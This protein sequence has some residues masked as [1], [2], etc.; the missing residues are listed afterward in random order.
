MRRETLL[1]LAP[2]GRRHPVVRLP[3]ANGGDP[4]TELPPLPGYFPVVRLRPGAIGLVEGTGSERPSLMVAGA[5]GQG[6]VI[7]ALSAAFWRLELLSSGVGGRPQTM[8]Q[9]WRNA[10]N[11]LAIKT[12]AGRVRA[13]T[14]R[15]V[16]RSGEPLIFVAQVFD[17]LL[18]PQEGAALQVALE[19]GELQFSLSDEGGG[20]Y[21][22]SWSGL[23][24]GEYTYTVRAYAAG[25][26]IG[27][28]R[29]RLLIEQHS[30]ESMDVR[31]DPALLGEMA[32]V[33]GGRI[34]PL[35]DWRELLE[36]LPLQQR[37]V[38][39]ESLMPL[40]GRTWVAIMVLALL[41][42]EWLVRKRCG[43]I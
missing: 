41:V 28:D 14:E 5:S 24:P 12:P 1:Q 25:S 2:Q 36:A 32:R 29:G 27:E 10:V 13:S 18:R 17:E 9:F 30:V 26:A 31:A 19:P 43:M 20:S 42:L 34:S 8:S 40:W 11:W 35:D 22:R 7:A 21:R 6:K 3:T 4:W 23:G 16:Y 15:P 33:S 38:E 37:L 39:K